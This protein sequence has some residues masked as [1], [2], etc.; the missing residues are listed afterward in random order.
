MSTGAEPISG[1]EALFADTAR[2]AVRTQGALD[3]YAEQTA[4]AG[5]GRGDGFNT[6]HAIPRVSVRLDFGL[7]ATS[8]ER[9][10]LPFWRADK[11][12]ELHEHHLEFSL[13]ATPES[14]PPAFKAVGDDRPPQLIQPPFLV[15]K[16]QHDSLIDGLCAAMRGGR[17]DFAVPPGEEKPKES[18]VF[19]EADRI[20]P[21]GGNTPDE[22]PERGMIVLQ[23]Q[24]APLSYLLVRVTKKEDKDGLFVLS[25]LQAPEVMIY[26]FEGD[27]VDNIVY[28]PLHRLALAIRSWIAGAPP[29][30]LNYESSDAAASPTELGVMA[31]RAI[32]NHIAGGYIKAVEILSR[33]GPPAGLAAFLP[34]YFDVTNAKAELRYSVYFNEPT[35]RM[36]FSFGPR[37]RPDGQ[38]AD[39]ELSVVESRAAVRVYRI[40]NLLRVDIE[41]FTPE[42]VL[43]GAARALAMA[44]LD[45]SKMEVARKFNAINPE[46][47][48]QFL[49]GDLFRAGAVF[50][51]SYA[52]NVPEPKLLVVWPA[53]FAGEARDFVFRCELQGDDP[54]TVR[55]TNI[56]RVLA[57]EEDIEVGAT[58][59]GA[60]AAAP[61]VLSKDKY[62]PFHNFFHAVR[63]WSFRMQV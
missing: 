6:F 52:G 42:F 20:R 48:L 41:L 32:A 2:A 45:R 27:G 18:K 24:A 58:T 59:P 39:S 30:R 3:Y 19:K 34:S 53:T 22:D 14:P 44:G 11:R 35:K 40:D 56:E 46:S 33:Q 57:L 61:P 1:I 15:P 4:A 29:L 23:L 54:E 50:F 62:T 43:S 16:A 5:G 13:V 31:L 36:E 28:E 7:Q 21:Q 25:P 9:V 55:L 12:R 47:Y 17:W 37:L 8:K 26:S 63:I 38:A 51:L 10:L 60:P 49:T